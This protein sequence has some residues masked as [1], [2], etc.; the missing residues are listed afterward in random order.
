MLTTAGFN[1][2]M[3]RT[4]RPVVWKAHGAQSPWAHPILKKPPALHSVVKIAEDPD[5]SSNHDEQD[6][7]G[8]HDQLEIFLLLAF[9]GKVQEEAE[10]HDQLKDRTEDQSYKADLPSTV[11]TRVKGMIVRTVASTK[12][13][14]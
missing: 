6:E 7:P 3:R 4:A 11:A 10:V 8:E 1:R 14:R 12:P 9:E 2:R 13:I 5:G